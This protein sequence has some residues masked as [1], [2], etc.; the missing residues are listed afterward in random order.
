MNTKLTL[1]AA[2][3]AVTGTAASA[4]VVTEIT[5]TIEALAIG[6]IV[7]N[8]ATNLSGVDGTINIAV[9]GS[10]GGT[11][12]TTDTINEIY[13]AA[14]VTIDAD[15]TGDAAS[16]SAN[17]AGG[18]LIGDCAAGAGSTDCGLSLTGVS[19]DFSETLS[20]LETTLA[21]TATFGD[22]ASTAIGAVNDT[23]ADVTEMAATV[24]T[25]SASNSSSTAAN[26]SFD[27]SFGSG[28][29]ILSGATNAADIA[30]AVDIAV[31]AGNTNFGA[32]GTT[33]AGAINTGN[34]I[35]QFVGTD[36]TA[37]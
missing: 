30:G 28:L 22:I 12:N 14:G 29:L 10:N 5:D 9:G 7:T 15:A 2:I 8:L 35:A 1:A 34:I 13:A 11:L 26:A 6:G 21:T 33:A 4:Q 36:T 17:L 24:S 19:V 27:S 20:E 16:S 18:L 25:S 3:L 31:D 37:P 32:V 23:T